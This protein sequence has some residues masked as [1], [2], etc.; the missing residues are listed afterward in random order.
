M[1]QLHC[2]KCGNTRAPRETRTD[3]DRRQ[4]TRGT[5]TPPVFSPASSLTVCIAHKQ[6]CCFVTINHMSAPPH[7]PSFLPSFLAL[8][9]NSEL[10]NGSLSRHLV[11]TAS[12]KGVTFR[13]SCRVITYEQHE[14]RWSSAPCRGVILHS[15]KI[16]TKHS[17]VTSLCLLLDN[18]R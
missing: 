18:S 10:N 11:N 13:L 14:R 2:S 17:S 5:P 12:N 4:K 7:L 1:A 6:T 16:C 8:F 3:R 15:P 9:I